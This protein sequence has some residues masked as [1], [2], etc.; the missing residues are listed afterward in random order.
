MSNR[1]RM[2]RV[3]ALWSPKPV[4]SAMSAIGWLGMAQQLASAIEPPG[5]KPGA[6][7]GIKFVQEQGV[8]AAYAHARKLRHRFGRPGQ[9]KIGFRMR[10]QGSEPR[11]QAWRLER[12]RI[13]QQRNPA[14]QERRRRGAPCDGK[15]HELD[16]LARGWAD[17]CK[18]P[19]RYALPDRMVH[20]SLVD[21][22]DQ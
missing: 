5:E 21:V 11:L 6:R 2:A 8:Q 19:L 7:A 22:D 18:W 1:L 16:Q 10:K 4:L 20:D 12:E 15:L 13:E 17:V 9:C 14:L 3:S